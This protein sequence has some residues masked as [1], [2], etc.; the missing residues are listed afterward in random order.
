VISLKYPLLFLLFV[1]SVA[2]AQPRVERERPL[3]EAVRVASARLAEGDYAWAVSTLEAALDSAAPGED[4]A[5]ALLVLATADFAAGQY[6]PALD[7]AREF[8]SGY[9]RH[10]RVSA[11]A[12]IRG[13]SAFQEGSLDEA[14][15]SFHRAY[16][17]GIEPFG[18]SAAY[19]LGRMHAS[20]G[21]LD[22]AERYIDR[23]LRT[24]DAGTGAS[25]RRDYAWHANLAEDFTDDALY[26]SAWIKEGRN[27]ID[28]AALSYRRILD[29]YPTSD[30]GL[31]AQLR[32]GVIDARRGRYE[33]ALTLLTSLTPRTERQREEQLFYMA[34]A[35]SALGR[36]EQALGDYR[37]FL[38]EFPTNRRER[39]A[40]YGAGWSEQQLGRYDDA[41][42]TYRQLADAH[43]SLAAASLYQIGAIQTVRADTA[44]AVRT[45][46][47]LL[48][49]LPYE[50]FSD[51]A[52][53]Q[54]GRIFY[55]RNDFDSARHYLNIAARQFP[56][57]DVRVEAYYLL[58]ESY[59]A[60][61]DWRNAQFSFQRT[62]QLD[63]TGAIGLRSLFREGVMLYRLGQFRSALGRLREYVS[64]HADAPDI[65]D[66]TFWL[67][68]ALYQDGAYDESERYFAV[69]LDRFANSSWSDEAL[70]GLAWAR[71]LQ[72]DF[73]SAAAAFE[74][75]T[76]L[77]PEHPNLIEATIRLADSY[78]YLKQW[79]RAIAI[80]NSIEDRVGKS[81]RGEEARYRLAEA[82]LEMGEVDRAVAAFRSLVT[83]YP[84]SARRDVY[85]FNVGSIYSEKEMDSLAIPELEQ[86]VVDYPDS[87][88]G[89]QA[90]FMIGD[91]WFNLKQYDSAFAWYAAVLEKYPAS[92][93]VPEAIDAVR[94]SLEPLGRGR[95]AIAIIDTFMARN[96]D[97]L[98]AD[99]LAFRKAMI[100][101]DEGAFAEAIPMFA[102]VPASFP[103]SGVVADALFQ[104][105]LSHEYLGAID[106]ALA[107]FGTVV[108][109]YPL[110]SATQRALLEQGALKMRM[111][112][113]GASR[114]NYVLF[115][116][117][118]PASTRMSEARYGLAGA[119]LALGDTS[120]ALEQYRAIIDSSSSDEDVLVDRSRLV[121][122]RIAAA[123]GS[124]DEALGI[125][126][127]VV[128]RRM[129]D[130]AA[131]ALLLRGELLMQA[132]DLAGALSE[133]KR[134]QSEFAEY[135]DQVEP[136]M[137]LLG[138]LYV[139][140]TNYQAARD[141]YTQ[142]ATQTENDDVRAEAER[143]IKKLKR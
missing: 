17:L 79:D 32:L 103:Q 14:R 86:F 64:K 4:R 67:A 55:R 9:P 61:E 110:S 28:S 15:A 24:V 129:D 73:D 116:E 120:A 93:I 80:Y 57:S 124:R 49:R 45:F 115:V 106:S 42:A 130:V 18:T 138:E 95:E 71:F 104:I 72:K 78:R 48:Y 131:E 88:L 122:A 69:H 12:Y 126:A 85:A 118:F 25:V 91:S 62:R 40:R 36:H 30:L 52:Y 27:E 75:F 135:T 20:A 70:Y 60:L 7:V 11:I 137:L 132:N 21:R 63:S 38:R 94:F 33:S 109:K 125:L 100:V 10:A 140:L 111:G 108:T 112:D 34:E 5:D 59:A 141:V 43:D 134:L 119:H 139:K 66:A 105:G 107:Y 114:S 92:P 142:L 113:P 19:W 46:E 127:S 136:G 39:P 53:Y 3:A 90:H 6:R 26:I 74:R 23:S 99:S 98:P 123:R 47:A 31:D 35:A 41:I 117:R 121:M 96:P 50:S 89:A 101:F 84:E 22:S 8:A 37:S 16:G 82:F 51:N 83:Y 133:L 102:T 44:G 65:A 29:E 128:A 56:E 54:L 58:A 81:A 76:T 13:V 68:E 97:R 87:R 143:R 1:C 2:V 77:Y